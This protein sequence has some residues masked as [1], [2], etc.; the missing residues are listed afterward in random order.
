MI[1]KSRQLL[2]K[3]KDHALS[4]LLRPLTDILLKR[5]ATV[6]N[7]Q[8]DSATKRITLEILPKGEHEPLTIRI[9]HYGIHTHNGI[10]YISLQGITTS[11]D[12]L[13]ALLEVFAPSLEFELPANLP[14][15]LLQCLI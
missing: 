13:N 4:G 10:N 3:H 7:I 15:K 1:N 9:E 6:L 8:L 12:W 11:R 14:L 2:Q 5:Y